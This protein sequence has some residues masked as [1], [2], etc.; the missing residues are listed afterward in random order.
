MEEFVRGA[1]LL[2]EPGDVDTCAELLERVLADPALRAE[3]SAAGRRARARELNWDRCAAA[4]AEVYDRVL[5]YAVS[6]DFAGARAPRRLGSSRPAGRRRR[7]HHRT[8]GRI[9]YEARCRPAPVRA[10]ATTSTGGPRSRPSATVHDIAPLKRPARLAWEQVGAPRLVRAVEADVWHGPHYTLPLRA[11]GPMRRHCAR[12][13]VLRPSR[14]ARAFESHVLPAHDACR[15]G[16]G[17]HR[18][19][20]ERVH[21]G[22][23][24]API[25]RRAARCGSCRT[26]SITIGSCRAPTRRP[27]TRTSRRTASQRHISR[28]SGTIEPRKDLPTL[29]ARVRAHRRNT[30]GRSSSCIA[31][32][33]GWGI[34]ALPRRDHREQRGDA[35]PA[36]GLR[37]QRDDRGTVPP[38]RGRRV[39]LARG[40]LRPARARSHGVRDTARVDH[41]FV[42]R[43]SGRR[44]RR[45]RAARRRRRARRGA[46]DGPRRRRPRARASSP[47]DP[48]RARRSLGNAPSK[49]I[50]T[51]TGTRPATRAWA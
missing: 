35:H 21:G 18:R 26:A 11:D 20:R 32:G 8:R 28:S 50:S 24:R 51:R 49:C 42:R 33:D 45:P 5:A 25:P 36:A 10:F 30:S 37:R 46:A 2:F 44:R 23:L 16:S 39:S 3:L 22:S 15:G 12:P 17:R 9:R 29:V 13:H 6:V 38:R 48:T 1:G 14:V 31:G 43:G 34:D 19:V 40:R 27:T 4:H 41:R 47:T 7:L